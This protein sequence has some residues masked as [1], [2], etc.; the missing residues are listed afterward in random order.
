MAATIHV[1]IDEAFVAQVSAE[2]LTAAAQA[3]LEAEGR[4]TGTLSIVVSGDETLRGL[5]RTYLGIDAPTDVLS[6]G[7]ESPDFVNAPDSEVYWGDVL[8]AYPQAEAQAV[9]ANHTIQ[10][11]LA[12]LVVHGILHLL[13]YDHVRPE[14]KEVMWERQARV[15]SQLGLAHV[16]PV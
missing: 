14:D 1:Q 2:W 11:E 6:F 13:G 9:A 4:T 10:A 7:G 3:I 5:N 16:Q 15:L 12:L 8:I